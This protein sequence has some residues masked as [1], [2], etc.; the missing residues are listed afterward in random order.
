MGCLT[1]KI[2]RSGGM[3]AMISNE[4][5]IVANAKREGGMSAELTRKETIKVK[6]E[7]LNKILVQFGLIC[8]ASYVNKLGVSK[9]HLWLLPENNFEDSFA[10]IT[11]V[12]WHIT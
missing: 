12:E 5:D 10:I 8:A 4:R 11:E 9:E 7:K 3:S 1:A 2:E 6:N